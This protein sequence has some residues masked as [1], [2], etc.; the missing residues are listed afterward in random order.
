VDV[1]DRRLVSIRLT[2]RGRA[3]AKTALAGQLDLSERWFAC[4]DP[5]EQRELN[6]LLDKVLVHGEVK[7]T[8]RAR[9]ASAFGPDS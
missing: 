7:P 9:A 5:E 1:Q 4:L 8:A 2:R 3:A 6:R